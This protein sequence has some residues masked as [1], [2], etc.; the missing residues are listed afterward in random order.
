MAKLFPS[1]EEINEKSIEVTEGEK[2]LLEFLNSELD[3]AYEVFF[4]P[5]LNGDKPQIVIIKKKYGIIIIGVKDWK[6]EDYYWNRSRGFRKKRDFNVFKSPFEQ[7]K[8]YKNNMYD[9][10]NESLLKKSIENKEVYNLIQCGIYFHNESV[11]KVKRE[12]FLNR[13]TEYEEVEII[14]KDSLE[15]EIFYEFLTRNHMYG[16][17]FNKSFDDKTYESIKALLQP[18]IHTRDCGKSIN[19]SNKQIKLMKSRAGSKKIKGVAGSGKT[20][21][22]AQRAVNANIRTKNKILILTYNITLKNYIYEKMNSIREEFN[23]VDFEINNYHRFIKF[24]LNN[25]AIP[26]KW[27]CDFDSEELGKYLESAK[28]RIERYDAIFIDEVQD[29]KLEWLRIIKKYFLK[30]NGEYVLFGDEKQNIYMRQLEEN[31]TSQTNVLGAWN[32]LDQSFRL[33]TKL[34]ILAIKFQKEF[35]ASKYNVDEVKTFNIQK[36]MWDDKG[37]IEY[38]YFDSFELREIFNKIHFIIYKE[39]IKLSDIC[40]I[41]SSIKNLKKIDFYIKSERGYETETTFESEEEYNKVKARL[42]N[43]F[44]NTIEKNKYN[45]RLKREIQRIRDSRKYNFK[46]NSDKIKLT[47]IHSFKGW[48]ADTLILIIDNTEEM[49]EEIIYTGITRCVNNLIIINVGNVKYDEFFKELL[50]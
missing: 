17:S 44:E 25:L 48:E 40:I 36:T 34:V 28:N 27:H 33:S 10:H 32:V 29:Y 5:N 45:K 13:D 12:L 30:K 20:L 1:L 35:L 11:A 22:L 26:F 24:Q 4:K 19:Y 9:L 41:G 38:F 21:M 14:G 16:S 47:T 18:H 46:M 39:K 43:N 3:N 31:R 50:T 8:E 37:I 49:I 6:L 7:V 2:S 42:I 15:R 23:P